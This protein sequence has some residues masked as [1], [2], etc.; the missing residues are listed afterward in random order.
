M[1][2]QHYWPFPNF[3]LLNNA[4]RQ[5]GWSGPELSE[6]NRRN[7]V[8]EKVDTM[9]WQAVVDD[10]RPFLD[11]TAD[12]NLLTRENLDQLLSNTG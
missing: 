1:V 6:D 10:V 2:G 11:T 7:L 4:L 8:R 5:T 3:I 12:A 9:S